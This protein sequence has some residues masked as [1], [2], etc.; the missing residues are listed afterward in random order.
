MYPD[1]F[2]GF[3][4]SSEVSGPEF[5]TWTSGTDSRL[6]PQC[7]PRSLSFAISSSSTMSSSD[8][9]F[10]EALHFSTSLSV[11]YDQG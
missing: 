11:P 2:L 6:S 10:L 9:P 7:V 1:S 8:S 3:S 4:V 5:M